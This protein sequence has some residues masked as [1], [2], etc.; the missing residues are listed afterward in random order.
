MSANRLV[1][2]MNR[3]Q[4]SAM[5]H[6]AAN[7]G[8]REHVTYRARYDKNGHMELE[9]SGKV[10]TYAEIQ[11]HK[12]SCDIHFILARYA[13]GDL[14]ALNKRP[15]VYFD[16]T[17][18]PKTFAD[19]LNLVADAKLTFDGLPADVR[20]QFNG[21][22]EQ[23]LAQAGSESWLRALGYVQEPSVEKSVDVAEKKEV[24]E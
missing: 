8:T 12:D 19:V 6:P 4:Y 11:S 3:T 7:S 18:M 24:V 23:F 13:N 21:S 16:A 22:Y 10:D 9:E 17:E 5:E 15:G 20:S 2:F 14:E 1:D